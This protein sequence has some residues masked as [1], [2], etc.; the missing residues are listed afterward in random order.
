MRLRLRLRATRRLLSGA[1]CGL[2]RLRQAGTRDRRRQRQ[3]RA[4]RSDRRGRDRPAGAG[5]ARP[6][7]D[8][9]R[10][11]RRERRHQRRRRHR[12]DRDLAG[13][14]RALA[15]QARLGQRRGRPAGARRSPT[16]SPPTTTTAG[17]CSS[18]PRRARAAWATGADTSSSCSSCSGWSSSPALVIANKPTKLGL[19][20]QGGLEL[21]YQ[22]Q[23]TGHRDRSQR[24]RHRRLDLDHRT[25]DQ[26]A[27]RLRA[28]SRAPRHRRDHGQPARRHRRQPRDRT[29]RHHR[30]ALLLRLGAE[31][32]RPRAGDRRPSRPATAARR[33]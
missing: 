28:R 9:P 21:V 18:S 12:P 29:G 33:R 4:D 20:L 23:P 19:D 25:A 6:R 1:E 22:G 2:L 5:G 13:V 31:P 32:A 11:R 26:Q 15:R 16:S 3:L 10:R 27:R 24:R 8:R 14:G 17:C 7:L 30:A